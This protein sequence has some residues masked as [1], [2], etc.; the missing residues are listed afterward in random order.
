MN[1]LNPENIQAGDKKEIKIKIKN[2]YLTPL[3]IE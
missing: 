3:S 1:H 2:A